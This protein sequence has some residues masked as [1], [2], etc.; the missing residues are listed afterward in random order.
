MDWTYEILCS[1]K[2]FLL[3]SWLSQVFCHS[4][5]KLTDIGID[6]AS[7]N[8]LSVLMEYSDGDMKGA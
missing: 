5:G 2:P 4:D 8:A 1:D 3:L 6:H 7:A